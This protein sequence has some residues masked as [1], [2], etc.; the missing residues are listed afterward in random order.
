MKYKLVFTMNNGSTFIEPVEFICSNP[1][2]AVKAYVNET[3]K[4]RSYTHGEVY[5]V[6]EE[7]PVYTS[8]NSIEKKP[9]EVKSDLFTGYVK[10]ITV[11]NN[12]SFRPRESS[13][14]EEVLWKS[15]NY[16]NGELTIRFYN[17]NEIS[18]SANLQ[19]FNEF[20]YYVMTQGNSAGKYFNQHIKNV[21]HRI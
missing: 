14:I 19:V 20:E 15:T 10:N 4:N 2:L 13:W 3:L 17:Q 9:I 7:T 1:L 12:L 8:N 6:V 18:Y 11:R 21:L 5:P 16:L